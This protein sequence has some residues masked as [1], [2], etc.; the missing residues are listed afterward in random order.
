M[1]SI[2]T[3]TVCYFTVGNSFVVITIVVYS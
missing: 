3:P 2:T 1:Y